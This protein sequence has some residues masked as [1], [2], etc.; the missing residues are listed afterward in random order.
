[1]P[2]GARRGRGEGRVSGD[3]PTGY[4]VAVHPGMLV[5]MFVRLLLLWCALGLALPAA[6]APV[7]GKSR[8][9]AAKTS[10]K[11]KKSKQRPKLQR[12]VSEPPRASLFRRRLL[13]Q[14][15]ICKT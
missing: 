11:S 5:G 10:K 9:P 7:S 12:P 14:P 6:A 1:M 3:T 15:L 8:A 13:K 4:C 2:N